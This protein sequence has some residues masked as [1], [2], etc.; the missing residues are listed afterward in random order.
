MSLLDSPRELRTGLLGAELIFRRSS[1]MLL[2]SLMSDGC[3]VKLA[4]VP[5]EEN[6][7]LAQFSLL[8]RGSSTALPLDVEPFKSASK[9]K[10]TVQKSGGETAVP[11]GRDGYL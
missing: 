10:Q 9:M 3:R 5:G 8:A 2:A 4:L 11:E 1:S 7:F 6:S